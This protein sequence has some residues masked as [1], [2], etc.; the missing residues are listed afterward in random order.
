[1]GFQSDEQADQSIICVKQSPKYLL[2][3][4]VYMNASIILLENEWHLLVSAR[5][6][7]EAQF[8]YLNAF[9]IRSGCYELYFERSFWCKGLTNPDI[10]SSIIIKIT[11]PYSSENI[12]FITYRV[13]QV[14]NTYY[15]WVLLCFLMPWQKISF[16]WILITSNECSNAGYTKL[17][18]LTL[19]SPQL[20][21]Y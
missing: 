5:E 19:W 6:R 11:F 20:Q 3:S 7:K 10:T 1:M 9:A 21:P 18:F 13:K 4:I 16:L 12:T 2:T 14:S 15:V 17:W 8:Q